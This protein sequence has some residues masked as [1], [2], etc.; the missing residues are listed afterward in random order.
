[1]ITVFLAAQPQEGSNCSIGATAQAEHWNRVHC[2]RSSV[3]VADPMIIRNIQRGVRE[4]AGD[5]RHGPNFNRRPPA[6][7]DCQSVVSLTVLV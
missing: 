1:M 5:A 2:V 3:V 6:N 7:P 4:V